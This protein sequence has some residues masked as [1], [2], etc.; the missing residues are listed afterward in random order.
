MK[1]SIKEIEEML[2]ECEQNEWDAV[3]RLL[4]KFREATSQLL[5]QLEE[6]KKVLELYAKQETYN[7]VGDGDLEIVNMA[8]QVLERLK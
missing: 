5:T 4:P 6:A 8:R 7:A 3:E 1:Y 2:S